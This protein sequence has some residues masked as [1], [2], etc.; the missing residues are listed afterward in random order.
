[1]SDDAVSI[2]WFNTLMLRSH[3]SL[4]RVRERADGRSGPQVSA[5]TED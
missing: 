4:H 1:M 3:E 5:E 2:G